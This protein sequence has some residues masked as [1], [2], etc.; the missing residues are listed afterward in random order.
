M[1]GEG[2]FAAVLRWREFRV[3]YVGELIQWVDAGECG[4]RVGRTL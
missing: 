4:G 3:T 1:R 2:R